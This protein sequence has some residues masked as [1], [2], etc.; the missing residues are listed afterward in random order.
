[1]RKFTPPALLSYIGGFLPALNPL[2]SVVLAGGIALGAGTSV[3][4]QLLDPVNV[5]PGSGI[6]LLSQPASNVVR[7]TFD[8]RVSGSTD[9]SLDGADF[10]NLSQLANG[11]LFSGNLISITANFQLL[12]YDAANA[13]DLWVSDLTV[14]I[15][16]SVG[17][18]PEPA[19]SG[20]TLQLGGTNIFNSDPA[21]IDLYWGGALLDPNGGPSVLS[22]F[23]GVSNAVNISLGASSTQEVWLANG[24]TGMGYSPGVWSGYIDFT[25]ASSGGSGVPDASRTALLLAPGTLLLLGLAGR[26][27]RRG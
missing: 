6:V 9:L 16:G 3:K 10:V 27:R 24:L 21:A 8:S 17:S 15:A 26:S 13:G 7:A 1:M 11:T 19:L 20:S 25:F 5:V 22:V 23:S 4:G 14:Y 12:N 18:P 2:R